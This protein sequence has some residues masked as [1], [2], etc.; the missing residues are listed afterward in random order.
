[1]QDP[2][3]PVPTVTKRVPWNKGKLIGAN[4]CGTSRFII[5]TAAR[6]CRAPMPGIREFTG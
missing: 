3:N 1:M 6:R 4:P 2:E 5:F